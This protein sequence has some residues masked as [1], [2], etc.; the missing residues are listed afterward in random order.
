M[1]LHFQ[2]TARLLAADMNNDGE[3]TPTDAVVFLNNH[4]RGGRARKRPR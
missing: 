2:A 4:P 3:V 1:F